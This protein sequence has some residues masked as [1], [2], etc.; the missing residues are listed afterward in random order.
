MTMSICMMQTAAGT[1]YERMLDITSVP[2][3]A[4]CL[5]NDIDYRSF[6]GIKRGYYNWQATYNRTPM[7]DELAREGF[8]GWVLFVDADAYVRDLDFDLRAYISSLESDTILVAAPG[9]NR[10][11]WDINAGVFLL[12]LGHPLGRELVNEWRQREGIHTPDRHMREVVEPWGRLSDGNLLINDQTMLHDVLR[13]PVFL[14]GLRIEHDLLNYA[15]GRFICQILRSSES[16]NSERIKKLA[17]QCANVCSSST[18]FQPANLTSLANRFGTDKGSMV[19]NAHSYTRY[20]SFMLEQ[21]RYKTF[22]ALEIGLLRGGPEAGGSEDRVTHGAPSIDMWLEY[23]PFST[24]YGIDISDFRS[25]QSS[26]FRFKQLDLSNLDAALA[27]RKALPSMK[28]I[29]EDASHASF[30]Q[31]VAFAAFFPLLESGGYYI[32]E[33]CDWQPQHF[34]HDLPSTAL[35]RDL[36]SRFMHFGVHNFPREI[37]SLVPIENLFDEISDVFVHRKENEDGS[38]GL[39]KLFAIRKV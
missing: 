20:Y 17:E 2:N 34:E 19:G 15:H 16:D 35:T 8:T 25:F 9:S 29:I 5:M 28:L 33:D 22:N 7:L 37:T 36:L 30:H 23:F 12:N 4:Y 31:Q 26:R 39:I 3:R 18:L 27:L 10:A 21:F 38:P 6:V 24:F 1:D 14:H 13:N 11:A 32:I